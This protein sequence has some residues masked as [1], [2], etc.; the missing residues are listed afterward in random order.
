[1]S[2][3]TLYLRLVINGQETAEV[4]PVVYRYGHYFV[5]AGVL[6]SNNVRTGQIKSGLIDV[7][8]LIDVKTEYDAAGQQLMLTVP[9]NW[10]PTQKI[11]GKSLLSYTPPSSSTGLLFNYDAYYL[12][13]YEGNST[14]TAWLEQR[15]FS[16]AGIISN[17]GTWRSVNASSDINAGY[18]GYIRYDTWWRYSDGLNMVSWQLGD[19]ISD[20][21]TWSNSVRM[22]GLRISRNFGVRPDLVT[23]PLLHYSGTAAVPGTVDLFI[24]GYKT[25]SS[26]VNPGPFTLTNVPSINGA[27]EATVVT[28]DALG[29]QVKTSVPFYVS[30]S[31]L[32]DGLSDFDASF[33]TLR[34]HYGTA[35]SDYSGMAFSGLYR[36]GIRD[37][38]TL[39]THTEAMDGLALVGLGSDIAVGYW[40]TFSSS[41]SRSHSRPGAD[42]TDLEAGNDTQYTLGYSYYATLFSLAAQHARRGEGW[43]DLTA[44]AGNGRPSRQADQVTFSSV[45]FGSNNGTLG[46]GYFDILA[47]DSTR[48]RLANLSYS[49]AL[50]GNSSI[51]LSLNKTLGNRGYDAQL[52]MII[53][54]SSGV[55]ATGS[56]Q[57]N[58]V[59]NYTGRMTMNRT[60]PLEGGT[61]WNLAWGEG[62]S[63]YRQADILWKTTYNKL[64]GGIWGESGQLNRWADMQGSLIYM[65]NEFFAANR[66]NDAFILVST[67]R[68]AGI[69]VRYE[70]QLVGKTD[71][72]GHVLV[73]WASAWYPAKIEIGT[74]D[75]PVNTE[76]PEVEKRVAVKEGSGSL[77]QFSVKKVRAASITLVTG[78]G[79]PLPVGT[80]VTELRSG[81][82]T[83]TG[84]AGQVF[85][86]HLQEE[87]ELLVRSTD[88]R[89]CRRA[90]RLP[91][92]SDGINMLGPFA[93][94]FSSSMAQD[95]NK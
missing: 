72:S 1:M 16:N 26:N 11:K 48:T 73:P 84:Y 56:L 45:P 57:K 71:K 24:N 75:L 35:N 7:D 8:K 67:D 46:L 18:R 14:L 38:L 90:F 9:D 36:Y 22:G 32:R 66:I 28:T 15:K 51:Y 5:E 6:A 79:S 52:Q 43:Q 60:A 82:S 4:V 58:T 44:M 59:G 40:G 30:N 21:L 10:L 41:Y 42:N 83:V 70:N 94:V 29:R 2:E 3:G 81:Q 76:I 77:V 23:Y 74:L 50:W 92:T 89:G 95:P 63:S 54:F 47:H 87:G 64:Q 78:N 85:F 37:W 31:L 69:P 33:G 34:K 19:F 86:S 27:G 88:G 25:N 91:D 39:S 20:S 65:D 13:P 55:T 80:P 68:Y 61:G 62:Q 53:P 49:R 12:D 93:C 17:T